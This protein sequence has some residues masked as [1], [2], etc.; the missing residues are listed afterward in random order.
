MKRAR[1]ILLTALTSLLLPLGMQAQEDAD[2]RMEIGVGAGAGFYLGDF[3]NTVF[4][5]QKPAAAAY[6]RYLFDHYNSLKVSLAYTGIKGSTKDHDSFYPADPNAGKAD[7]T[8][9][10]HTFSGSVVDLSCM[11]EINF[12]PYGFYQDFFG[13]KRLTPFLQ[14]GAGMAYASEGKGVVF[15]IPMGCGLKYRA[16][17]RVNISLDWT[18]HFSLSDKLDGV[19]DPLGIKSSGFKNK[20]HFGITMLTV[21]Y[22]FAPRCQNCNKDH[23]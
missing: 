11:Y 4:A 17:R 22:S 5:N 14:I 13:H 8:P 15:N 6:W 21:T 2:F 19:E 16:S 12:F 3:N 20:D 1:L 18:M 7:P 10:T 9:L 23:R